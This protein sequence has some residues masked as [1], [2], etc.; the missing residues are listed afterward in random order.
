MSY[1][2]DWTA[3]EHVP[4]RAI[5]SGEIGRYGALSPRDGGRTWRN[6]LSAEW[7]RLGDGDAT[8]PAPT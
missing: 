3:T 5:R 1:S 6:S 4:E 8:R 7:A 2:A